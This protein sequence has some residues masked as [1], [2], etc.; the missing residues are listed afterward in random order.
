MVLQGPHVV[1]SPSLGPVP[2]VTFGPL[3]SDLPRHSLGEKVVLV[4]RIIASTVT[5][6]RLLHDKLPT[7]LLGEVHSILSILEGHLQLHVGGHWLCAGHPAHEGICPVLGILSAVRKGD[8]PVLLD[9]VRSLGEASLLLTNC[10]HAWLPGWAERFLPPVGG[11]QCCNFR[12]FIGKHRVRDRDHIVPNRVRT[13]VGSEVLCVLLNLRL[14]S[15]KSGTGLVVL[16]LD[17]HL[18]HS[19]RGGR[20]KV[21]THCS[22]PPE[23]NGSSSNRQHIGL[24]FGIYVPRRTGESSRGSGGSG[25]N[26]G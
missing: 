8:H 24:F 13:V 7:P 18:G 23:G 20:A 26:S 5:E 6:D 17:L 15:L 11:V 9:A 1:R 16:L 4:L 25:S 21:N 12:R 22:D 2:V 3:P 10:D 14:L 19:G